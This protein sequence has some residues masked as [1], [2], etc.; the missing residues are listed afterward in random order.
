MNRNTFGKV[1]RVD[2]LG[3]A[4]FAT[5]E[6]SSKHN[7][8]TLG[9]YINMNI[10]ERITGDFDTYATSVDPMYM[11][12]Y[13]HTIDSRAFGLSYLFAIGIPS[14]ISASKSK[15]IVGD[16]NGLWTHDVFWTELRANRRAEKYFRKHYGVNWS[17]RLFND[18]PLHY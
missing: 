4:T 9:N 6:N 13:G 15:A 12:E 5:N 10:R 14:A 17:G 1:D 2:Y 18:Y 11:H 3:G 16:P 7:G 8:I